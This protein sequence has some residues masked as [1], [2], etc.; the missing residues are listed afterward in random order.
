MKFFYWWTGLGIAAYTSVVAILQAEGAPAHWLLSGHLCWAAPTYLLGFTVPSIANFWKNRS[1]ARRFRRLETR[2]V[3]V[4]SAKTSVDA[5]VNDGAPR[6]IQIEV[7]DESGSPLPGAKVCAVTSDGIAQHGRTDTSGSSSLKVPPSGT[8]S[9]YVAA[10][11]CEPLLLRDHP[12]EQDL[13]VTLASSSAFSSEILTG[14]TGYLK[15][16]ISGRI[17]PI[18]DDLNR[19]YVY[20]D[21][22]SVNGKPASPAHIELGEVLL[23]KDS[24]FKESQIQFLDIS[25]KASLIRFRKLEDSGSK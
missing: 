18:H 5:S 19:H 15:G 16:L 6:S 3:S 1:R 4:S 12:C 24:D 20:I 23:V 2:S 10:A 7:I 25:S 14:S 22:A 9:I 11:N 13:K 17:N 8:L 21:N